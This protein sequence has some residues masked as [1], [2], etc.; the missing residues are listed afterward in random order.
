LNDFVSWLSMTPLSVFLQ[1]RPWTIMTLQSIH[2]MAIGVVLGSVFMI[3]LRLWKTAGLDQTVVQTQRRFGPWLLGALITLVVTGSFLVIA[4]P[5]REF[6]AFS[7]W[8][9]MTL[10]VVGVSI[11]GA[12]HMSLKKNAALWEETLAGHGFVK[13][14]AAFTLVVWLCIIVLG[15]LIAY[16]YLWG[17]LSPAHSL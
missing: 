1:A 6:F 7:F 17:P 13:F 9:K 3:T 14:L 12:F 4:E 15:R 8:M 11:A 16:D 2:I 5:R 10:L